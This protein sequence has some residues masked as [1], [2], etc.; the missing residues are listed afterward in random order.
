MRLT[1]RARRKG[2]AKRRPAISDEQ[3]RL[4]NNKAAQYNDP[5]PYPEAE[6]ANRATLLNEIYLSLSSKH[7]PIRPELTLE[8][9]TARMCLPKT[10]G[11]P[12]EIEEQEHERFKMAFDGAGAFGQMH[13]TLSEHLGD[14]GQFPVGGFMGYGVLQNL[15]QNPAISRAISVVADEITKNWIEIKGGEQEDNDRV[16]EL[17]DLMNTRYNL[18]AIFRSAIRKVGFYGGA[19]IFI[20]TGERDDLALPLP[21]SEHSTELV[22]GGNLSFRVVDPVTV[23]PCDYNSTRPLE[24]DYMKP[25]SW[26]VYGQEVHASRLLTLYDDEPP[27]LLKPAYNFLGI[28]LAQ[29]LAD[30]VAHWNHSRVLAN[31]ALNKVNLLVLKTSMDEAFNMPG[32]VRALDARLQW[33]QRNRNANS[34]FLCD[35]DTEDVQNVQNTIAGI[36]DIVKMNRE[37]FAAAVGVPGVKLFGL[38]PGGFNATGESDLKSFYDHVRAQQEIYRPQIQR[39]L[40]AIQLVHFGDIDPTISF[41]FAQ[42]SADNGTSDAM[43]A[44]AKLTAVST[45]VQAGIISADE[46]R[47]KIR[48]DPDLGYE[49]LDGVAP[50]NMDDGD[51]MDELG[52]MP[53]TDE[54]EQAG[55]P[56][57]GEQPPID[58]PSLLEKG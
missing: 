23:S 48:R 32:G 1:N 53:P 43:N 46:G 3:K 38:S 57:G 14:L 31:E 47:E 42:V 9:V 29:K 20:D 2:G 45:A 52:D 8:E 33:Y 11:M 24:A 35:N 41:D 25:R 56:L 49:W 6:G 50:D 15:A 40:N 51:D 30:S 17:T 54:E 28:P 27:E 37:D 22:E 21:V 5:L 19:F 34:V 55:Q 12:R 4:S 44:Q 18:Q 10:L 39:C 36:A 13:H 7:E 16:A 58:L 26:W